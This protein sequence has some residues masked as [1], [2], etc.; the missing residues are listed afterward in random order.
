[1]LRYTGSN[2]L[3]AEYAEPAY[4]QTNVQT[5]TPEKSTPFARFLGKGK[6]PKEQRIE[7]KKRGIGRQK[8][9]FVG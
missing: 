1:M 4:D 2:R 6:Y 3:H 9:P 8:Y 5:K 7:D